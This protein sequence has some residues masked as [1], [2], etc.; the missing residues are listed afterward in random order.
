MKKT[1]GL[2]FIVS[3]AAAMLTLSIMACALTR[4]SKT[5]AVE[6]LLT[7]AGFKM[8]VADTPQKLAELKKLPQ[9]EIVPHEDGDKLVYIYVDAKNCQCA[10][11]GDEKA[12]QK[13]QKLNH[14]RQIADEDR[15]DAVRNKQSQMDSGDAGFGR[16]W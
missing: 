7:A 5:A 16:N 15:R 1:I 9:R 12:Y 2:K 10:F 8:G 14:A 6:K 3:M 11:V 4:D 13:Y